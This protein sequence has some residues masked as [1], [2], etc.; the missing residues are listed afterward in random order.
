MVHFH[1]ETTKGPPLKETFKSKHGNVEPDQQSLRETTE[2]NRPQINQKGK[3]KKSR[4][5]SEK[6]EGGGLLEVDFRRGREE[7]ERGCNL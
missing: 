1:Q 6:V 5:K 7:V 2:G 4:G 3:A